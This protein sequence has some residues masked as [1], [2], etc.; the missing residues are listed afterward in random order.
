[1]RLSNFES[2]IDLSFEE[3]G[4]VIIE[5]YK[6]HFIFYQVDNC[7]P[8]IINNTPSNNDIALYFEAGQNFH[9]I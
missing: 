7:Y 3:Q 9:T 4:R 1:M 5:L 8:D 6:Q 2:N